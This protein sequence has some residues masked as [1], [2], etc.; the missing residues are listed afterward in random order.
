MPGLSCVDQ[1]EVRLR[2]VVAGRG[3]RAEI[4][5]IPKANGFG[6]NATVAI[7]SSRLISES[8]I[9]DRILLRRKEH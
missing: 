4:G 6:R 2:G 5:E 9:I 8:E 7:E 3:L 1:L